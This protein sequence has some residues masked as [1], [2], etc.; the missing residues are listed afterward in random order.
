MPKTST[1]T[2]I[3]FFPKATLEAFRDK[4][5]IVERPMPQNT[6]GRHI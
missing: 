1:A 4:A 5:D 6:K 2:F 3:H